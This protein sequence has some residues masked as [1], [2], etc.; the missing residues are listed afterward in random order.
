MQLSVSGRPTIWMN[1]V[2]V[3]AVFAVGADWGNFDIFLFLS[4][5]LLFPS[6]WE[7]A[8]YRLKYSLKE[9]LNPKQPINQLQGPCA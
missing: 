1:V 4:Y 2:E 5:S 8:R 9:P 6:L 3:P 7:N